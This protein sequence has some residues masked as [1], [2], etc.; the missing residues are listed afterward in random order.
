MLI[1]MFTQCQPVQ[2]IDQYINKSLSTHFTETQSVDCMD[3][4]ALKTPISDISINQTTNPSYQQL[5][6]L[7]DTV[8]F[9][10]YKAPECILLHCLK[11]KYED[12]L[13]KIN[14]SDDVL[15]HKLKSY[16][17]TFMNMT[18]NC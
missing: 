13:K 5:Q 14:W 17:R 11:M 3:L 9:P 18:R 10:P 6:Q 4:F 7:L 16:V 8:Q 15:H 2:T 1:H 12:T